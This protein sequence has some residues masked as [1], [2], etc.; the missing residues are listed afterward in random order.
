MT[1][2]PR[3]F[4]EKEKADLALKMDF[5]PRMPP[6]CEYEQQFPPDD[7]APLSAE[8]EAEL[9]SWWNVEAKRLLENPPV[10]YRLQSWPSP[11][12][13]KRAGIEEPP[14]PERF[15]DGWKQRQNP[16]WPGDGETKLVPQ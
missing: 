6:R 7:A 4:T 9:E 8:E 5:E 13:W 10:P 11:S 15:T 2:P 14:K 12:W 16:R 3:I 1:S